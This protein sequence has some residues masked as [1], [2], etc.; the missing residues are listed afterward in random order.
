MM[1][2]DFH[3]LRYERNEEKCRIEID[4]VAKYT[5]PV[6]SRNELLGQLSIYYS[7]P[8]DAAVLDRLQSRAG[9]GEVRGSLRVY[10][11]AESLKRFERTE[12]K[13]RR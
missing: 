12:R 8:E 5:G 2:M 9:R 3:F 11:D 7:F 6:P 1:A 10:R 4:F 13:R